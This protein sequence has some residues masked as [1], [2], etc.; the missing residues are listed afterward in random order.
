MFYKQEKF[1]RCR[2]SQ[3]E[4]DFSPMTRYPEY[5]KNHPFFPLYAGS[6]RLSSMIF[7]SVQL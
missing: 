3:K 4:R 2:F 5:R 1:Y 6:G 7:R